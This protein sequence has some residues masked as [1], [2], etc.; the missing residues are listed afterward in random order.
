MNTIRTIAG[1]CFVLFTS[2]T[3]SAIADAPPTTAPALGI[4]FSCVGFAGDG[5]APPTVPAVLMVHPTGGD[6]TVLLQGA[7]DRAASL[8]VQANGFR[9]AVL[10]APG[11]FHI[12]GQLQMAATGVVLRGAENHG[13]TL[14]ATGHSRRTLIEMGDPPFPPYPPAPPS[15]PP[16]A[17]M[18]PVRVVGDIVP[19]GSR[20][21]TLESTSGFNVGDSITLTRPSPAE[22]IAALGMKGLP[23][24]FAA[25]RIDWTPGSR[26]LIWDRTITAIDG[27]H[28]EITLDAP[29]TTA[30]ESRYGG[31][32]V[33]L[34]AATPVRIGVEELLLDSAFD[35]GNACDEEHAWI[36]VAVHTVKDGWVRNVTARHFAGSAVR[37]GP[38]ARRITVDGCASEEPISEP[39]GYRRQ[40]FLV[41]GQQVLV[42]RCTAEMGMN[43]FAVGL[44]AAGPNVF[45]DCSATRALG[46]S[47]SFE[48]WASGVL[49]ENVRIDGAGIRLTKDMTRAQGG[50]WT[51]VNSV[52]SNCRAKEFQMQGPEGAP[53]ILIESGK[54]LYVPNTAKAP[55]VMP[56]GPAPTEFVLAGQA[57]EP[58]TAPA[59]PGLEIVNGHFVIGK[60]ALWGGAV[61][62]AWWK[63]EANPAVA[64]NE[65]VDITRFVPGRDGPGLTENLPALAARMEAEGTPFYQSGP[66]LWYD[67]RRDEHS[68]NRREDGN[69][70]APF[71]ELPWARSGQYAAG[72]GEGSNVAAWDGLSRYDLTRYNTWYFDRTRT[73]VELC[74]Q[75]GI[76]MFH[77]FYNTHNLLEWGAHWIDSPWRPAN[78]IN[79][80]GLMEPP[81]LE[82][83]YQKTE[84]SVRVHYA[85]Q[86]YNVDD[87]RRRKLHHDYIF[88]VLNQ[89]GDSPNVVFGVAYQFPGPLAFQEFFLDTLAEWEQQSG[90]HVRIE[91]ATSKDITDAILADPVRSKQISVV[92]LRYWQYRPDGSLWA[93]PGGTNHAFREMIGKAF[94]GTNDFPPAT[95]PQQ[96]YRQ[97]REYHDR[98][99]D[100]AIVAWNGGVGPAPILFAGGAECLNRN[101]TGGHGQRNSDL[102]PFDAMVQKQL[103]STLMNL[104]PRDGVVANATTTWCLSDQATHTVVVYSL[105]G[106]EITFA[107]ALEGHY[108][109]RWLNP[110]TGVSQAIAEPLTP[111]Q[112]MSIPK[113]TA[114]PWILLM[115]TAP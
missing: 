58:S 78:N 53:N 72:L 57:T 91:L 97:V 105:D 94:G 95:T 56:A 106:K 112:Q 48:S 24:T 54:P 10:L 14:L 64:L 38:H 60:R 76:V 62:D 31:G 45:F 113:P 104:L 3:A 1:L 13:T 41:E 67:R 39:G 16:T 36:A 115:E 32:T 37:V 46:A 77:S 5:S 65:G 34:T 111:K 25:I 17:A 30:L 90:H 55:D 70:W 108:S 103:G 18:S 98:F 81:P 43:D 9:G 22:W 102:I 28:H 6:D 107:Q 100:K 2:G 75:H 20:S 19:A 8:P 89:I 51:A 79:Q 85:N 110:R 52:V 68:V 96:L 15:H 50:G 74:H 59:V 47:G 12:E 29:I 7:L 4:D 42:E 61:N 99:P 71:C 27:D 101:P 73:F 23:G 63:G 82:P 84:P 69:V 44:C 33:A 86:F 40:S 92:D 114:E 80:T 109:A 93:P 26:N 21:F 11:T 83:G 88:H 49:Y 66:G 35:K 87:P